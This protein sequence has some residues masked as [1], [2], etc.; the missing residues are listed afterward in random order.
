MATEIERKFLVVS[1]G[2]RSAA[3][4]GRAMQQ[5][6]LLNTPAASVRLRVA[7]TEAWLTVKGAA[8]R[9]TR[10]EYEY[11][12]PAADASAMLQAFCP[13][14]LVSKTRYR[15]PWAE[16]TWEV[17]VF[18]GDNGGLVVAELELGSEDEAFELPPWIGREVTDV[19][20]YLNASLVKHPW[21]RWS[22]AERRSS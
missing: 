9:A 17:D 15:V 13:D 7:D 18:A 12:I 21:G 16:H 6:Y 8:R 3:G 19:P 20:R 5:G 22:E 10:L 14:G 11:P 2:W 1:D 4:P